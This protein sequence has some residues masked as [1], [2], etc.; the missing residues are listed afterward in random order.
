MRE[1]A[2]R[3]QVGLRTVNGIFVDENVRCGSLSDVMETLDI[4]PSFHYDK[5]KHV[6]EESK[7]LMFDA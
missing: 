5:V 2:E 7:R 6:E 3:S 1:I 4:D